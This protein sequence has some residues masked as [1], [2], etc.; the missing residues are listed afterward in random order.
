MKPR[1]PLA[2]RLKKGLREA[3]AHEKGDLV[4]LTRKVFIHTLDRRKNPKRDRA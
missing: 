4:L 3:I 2:E 1:A